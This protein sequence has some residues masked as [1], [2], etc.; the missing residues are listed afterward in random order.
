MTFTFE[1]AD[2]DKAGALAL[3]GARVRTTPSVDQFS[4][5]RSILSAEGYDYVGGLSFEGYWALRASG[6]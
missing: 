2:R 4:G 6:L 3:K 5:S 1:S